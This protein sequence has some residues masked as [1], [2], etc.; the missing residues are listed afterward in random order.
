MNYIFLITLEFLLYFTSYTDTCGNNNEV[1]E[2]ES[3]NLLDNQ[4]PKYKLRLNTLGL[5]RF[6]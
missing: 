3:L 2:I 4:V 6:L 5:L 1:D